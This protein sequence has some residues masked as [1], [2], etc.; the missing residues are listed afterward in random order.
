M[1]RTIFLLSIS[2]VGC[3]TPQTPGPIV[4]ALN[5]SDPYSIISIYIRDQTN[6]AN[7]E[8]GDTNRLPEDIYRNRV[9]EA[10]ALEKLAKETAK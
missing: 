5:T 9:N 2:L 8:Y 3:T 4:E 6:K 10:N 7:G 1:K